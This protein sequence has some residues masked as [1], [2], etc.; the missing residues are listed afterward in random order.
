[1]LLLTFQYL[2][3]SISNNAELRSFANLYPNPS[4][5]AFTITLND[6]S[7][8]YP[9]TLEV[10]NTLGQK[11]HELS[12]TTQTTP[13]NMSTLPKGM[14]LLRAAGNNTGNAVRFVI[15]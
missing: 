12:I 2:G 4:N 11:M 9:V 13:V 14:Y 1:M 8:I 3:V 10:I 15:Q 6:A 7:V 5:G